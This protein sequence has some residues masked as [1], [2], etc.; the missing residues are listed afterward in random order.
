M[1]ALRFQGVLDSGSSDRT[2]LKGKSG[3]YH[4]YFAAWRSLTNIPRL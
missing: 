2:K 1:P 3:P 4:L